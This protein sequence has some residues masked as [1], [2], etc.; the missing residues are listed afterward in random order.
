MKT[1][2]YVYMVECE[3]GSLYTGITKDVR[4]RMKEHY[5]KTEKGAKYTRSHQIRKIR[6]VWKA[7]TYAAAA[8]LEYAIKQLP[9]AKKLRLIERPEEE[10]KAL[11][12][13]LAEEKYEPGTEYIMDICNLLDR[14]CM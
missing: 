6:M 14:N 4:Q 10:V 9:R 7:E 11:F 12:P 13:K 5:D 8:R 1:E 2:A 3:D